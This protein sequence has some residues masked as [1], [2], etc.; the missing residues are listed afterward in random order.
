[1]ISDTIN[2]IELISS[3]GKCFLNLLLFLGSGFLHCWR[4]FLGYSCFES[5]GS[6]GNINQF[7]FTGVEGM[8]G[9]ANFNFNFR[10]GGTYCK[11]IAART[12]DSCI[13]VV[14]RMDVFLHRIIR[15]YVNIRIRANIANIS[16][17]LG[18]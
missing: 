2:R 8:A 1:M 12:T 14:C 3:I 11:S 16:A 10:L 9:A 13:R 6:T 5:I 7:A 18:S 15:Q 4:F 17:V